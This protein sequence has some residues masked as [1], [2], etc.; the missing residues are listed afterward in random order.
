MIKSFQVISDAAHGWVKVPVTELERLKIQDKISGFSYLKKGFAFLEEDADA[1]VFINARVAEGNPVK[2][3]EINRGN[4]A[5]IRN[6][7][8]YSTVLAVK[9]VKVK[10]V[11]VKTVI[12]N[13]P[14]VSTVETFDNVISNP[15]F[16]AEVAV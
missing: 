1:Q 2:L 3:K 14:F 12:S 15:P 8:G 5:K 4:C 9:T 7:P 6:Y 11:K 13:L 10:P 16:V